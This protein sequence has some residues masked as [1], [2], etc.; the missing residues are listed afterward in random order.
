MVFTPRSSVTKAIANYPFYAEQNAIA[1]A[2]EPSKPPP[3]CG[4]T[5]KVQ[6]GST[7]PTKNGSKRALPGLLSCVISWLLIASFYALVWLY[8]GRV[9]SPH[10]KSTFD[11]SVVW[12]G[13]VFGLNIASGLEEI[14]LDLRWWVLN[15]RKRSGAMVCCVPS[16]N[17]HQSL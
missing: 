6:T 16:M 14:A 9:I 12:L 15:D 7:L 8:K 3:I 11:A 10:T 13:I 5:L 1:N 2:S 4:L 17:E